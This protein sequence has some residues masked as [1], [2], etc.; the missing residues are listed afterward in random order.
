[1]IFEASKVF[2]KI[3]RKF[4]QKTLD[5]G[6]TT[7]LAPN[8]FPLKKGTRLKKRGT[9]PKGAAQNQMLFEI[10]FVRLIGTPN[11]QLINNMMCL[12]SPTGTVSSS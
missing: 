2:Q 12:F 7:C 3:S 9:T 10:Y 4:F 1:L 6:K 8:P 11:Q 5:A